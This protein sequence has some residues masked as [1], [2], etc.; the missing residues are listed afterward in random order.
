[1]R[2]FDEEILKLNELDFIGISFYISEDNVEVDPGDGEQNRLSQIASSTAEST[3]PNEANWDVIPH[4]FNL[5]NTCVWNGGNF[6]GGEFNYSTWNGGNFND[7]TINGSIWRNGVFNY[8]FMN[9]CYWEDGVWRNGNWNGSPY[10]HTSLSKI[11]DYWEISN[12]RVD[13]ILTNISNYSLN[14]RIHLS[15]IMVLDQSVVDVLHSFDA[16]EFYKWRV[17]EQQN[18]SEE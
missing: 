5:S 18:I 9:N 10:D 8:G 15:N 7:G 13:Q 16:S 11:T 6:N 3:Y 1:V 12:K 17:D 2:I 4:S 14:T